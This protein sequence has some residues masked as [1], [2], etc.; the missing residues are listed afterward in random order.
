VIVNNYSINKCTWK[1]THVPYAMS[2]GGRYRCCTPGCR[3]N[4][5]SVH[6]L[7]NHNTKGSCNDKLK[8]VYQSIAEVQKCRRLEELETR[9]EIIDA[10]AEMPPP[11]P[12]DMM[13]DEGTS[14]APAVS[15]LQEVHYQSTS[16]T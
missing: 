6:G 4:F 9:K 8:R 3:K 7:N 15:V 14:Q 5:T 10:E 11:T 13:V 12:D 16:L 1:A 2:F